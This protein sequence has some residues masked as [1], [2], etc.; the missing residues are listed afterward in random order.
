MNGFQAL[1]DIREEGKID[2]E[3]VEDG[4]EED[5]EESE[6]EE[7]KSIQVSGKNEKGREEL[8]RMGSVSNQRGRGKSSKRSIANTRDL[9]QAVVA[10]QNKKASSRRL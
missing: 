5:V 1:Q 3:D 9:R 2:E 4:H 7:G 8:K 10:N 6:L